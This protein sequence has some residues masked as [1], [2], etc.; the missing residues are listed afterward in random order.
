MA[1][2][3][4]PCS[5]PSLIKNEASEDVQRMQTRSKLLEETLLSLWDHIRVKGQDWQWLHSFLEG[6]ND[7]KKIHLLSALVGL[8][9]GSADLLAYLNDVGSCVRSFL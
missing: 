7:D 3:L 4:L 6:M 9:G 8:V 1:S 2:D 5:L